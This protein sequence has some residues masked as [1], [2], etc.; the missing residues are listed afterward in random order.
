MIGYRGVEGAGPSDALRCI[1]GN[2]DL[3]VSGEG[4]IYFTGFPYNSLDS[5]HQGKGYFVHMTT[6]GTLTYDCP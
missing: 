2:Y 6:E 4:K 3:V 5:L 1:E